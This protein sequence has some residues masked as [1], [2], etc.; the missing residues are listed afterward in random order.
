MSVKRGRNFFMNPGPTNIPDRVLR[1][2]DRPALD[3]AQPEFKAIAEECF[4]G[5]KR[6]FTTEQVMVVYAAS[7]HGAWEAAVVNLCSAGDTVLVPET[8]HFSQSWSG[9]VR[10][11]GINVET[12]PGDW[13][14]GV[15]PAA[16]EEK[17]KADPDHKIRAVLQVHNETSTGV[18][19]P[20]AG[21]RKA[22]DAAKHPA[23]Y[24]VDTIS[25]LGSFD[26]RMDDW[27]VDVAVGG[28]QKGL[29]LPPG[30][31]FTGVSRKALRASQSATLP[32]EYWSW[33]RMLDGER[34]TRFAGTAPVHHIFGLQESLKMIDEEGL[35][36]IFARHARLGAAT[37]A[38][39]KKWSE[40]GG[41]EL[42]CTN[43]DTVSNSVTAVWMPE[44]HDANELR[45]V[46]DGRF[47]VSLGGGLSKLNGRVF[48]IGHMGDLNEPMLM[49]ALS[50]IEMGLA[51]AK[52]PHGKGGAAA[53][54]DCLQ[55]A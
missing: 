25:S 37:R 50:A 38:C 55:A 9:M 47:N 13:R 12:V 54:M 22:I 3:F 51:I 30:M 10:N 1:A 2:M 19:H 18:A 7:G 42:Y 35:D 45:K 27:G 52:V 41:P 23:L 49:G 44:G 26:F 24:L 15:D 5:L 17:L 46:V 43:P 32:R 28:S 34:Q 16:V 33:S 6:V 4:A 53:A 14:K 40:G 31:C 20:I 29:M 48:R 21:V 36:G 8:G 39:V 11:Y